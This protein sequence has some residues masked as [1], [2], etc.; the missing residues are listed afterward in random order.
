MWRESHLFAFRMFRSVFMCVCI[1]ACLWACTR[2]TL[3][4]AAWQQM[5]DKSYNLN[6]SQLTKVH[7]H[8]H[9][10]A[11][12]CADSELQQFPKVVP[13]SKP[14]DTKQ[15]ARVNLRYGFWFRYCFSLRGCQPWCWWKNACVRICPGCC[16]ISGHQARNG[17]SGDGGRR[18]Y[19]V[20]IVGHTV[21]RKRT[22]MSCGEDTCK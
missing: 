22:Q 9:A 6:D 18:I 4:K 5:V 7:L 8:L 3:P 11:M 20:H 2:L 17:C 15:E 10:F 16:S 1:W 21:I 12:C 19:L 14:Y 13:W